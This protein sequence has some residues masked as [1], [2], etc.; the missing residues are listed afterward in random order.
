MI[1]N[2]KAFN[3]M[4]PAGTGK[5][6][7]VALFKEHMSKVD[8]ER[9]ILHYE[10]GQGFRDLINESD[11]FVSKLAK[12]TMMGEGGHLPRFMPVW[13]WGRRLIYELEENQ[14]LLIDGSPRKIEEMNLMNEAL[15]YVGFDDVNIIYITVPIEVSVE[16]LLL[17]KRGDDSEEK[18]RNRLNWFEKEVSQVVEFY[19]NNPKY[20]FF[21]INGDQTV[22]AVHEDIKKAL[23]I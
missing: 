10:A 15:E 23:G 19:K 14:H 7:Q 5:G 22:E 13:N 20:K 18:I 17:R 1:E 9:T 21:E 4:G 6:T 2:K 12:Q 11:S 8:P 16:R 3:F